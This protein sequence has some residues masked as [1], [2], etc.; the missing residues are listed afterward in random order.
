MFLLGA[1]QSTGYMGGGD[2]FAHFLISK[3]AFRHPQLF[4]DHWGKPLFTMISA[5]FARWGIEGIVLFNMLCGLFTI[6]MLFRHVTKEKTTTLGVFALSLTPYFISLHISGLTEPLFALLLLMSVLMLSDKRYIGAGLLT[7]ALLMVRTEGVLFIGMAMVTFMAIRKYGAIFWLF[8]PLILVSLAGGLVKQGN[9]FWFFT[10]LP[11]GVQSAYASGSIW[12]FL[13][14]AD[15]IFGYPL[16]VLG[17]WGMFTVLRTPKYDLVSKVTLVGYP[18]AY[19]VFHSV[20]FGFG[21]GASAG[22]TRVMLVI[23]PLLALNMGIGLTDLF[24]R[25]GKKKEIL[26]GMV[27]L[28]VFTGFFTSSRMPVYGTANQKLVKQLSEEFADMDESVIYYF[29]PGVAVYTDCD[30]FA[31]EHCI[32]GYPEVASLGDY[33]VWD[34]HFGPQEGA[35]PLNAILEDDTWQKVKEYSAQDELF[36]L[37]RKV[38]AQ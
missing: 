13:S 3:Y 12:Y 2:T 9:F 4:F 38:K 20:L 34:S 30:P 26:A 8:V 33:L 28:T 16:L 11:Y 25:L 10:E 23:M 14:K 31:R 35:T 15:L 32:S 22:L 29:H 19:F 5:P 37:F 17:S 6:G 18:L 7:G 27:V 24:N 36:I 21:L 1:Y